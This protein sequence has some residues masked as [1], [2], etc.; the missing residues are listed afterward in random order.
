MSPRGAGRSAQ[1]TERSPAHEPASRAASAGEDPMPGGMRRETG[2]MIDS[3]IVLHHIIRKQ[4][5]QN[6]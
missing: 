2:W 1:Y 6:S 5:S 4:R 3:N